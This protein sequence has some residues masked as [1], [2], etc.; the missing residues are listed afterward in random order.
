MKICSPNYWYCWFV[1]LQLYKHAKPFSATR[2]L[3]RRHAMVERCRTAETIALLSGTLAAARHSDLL[4][5]LRQLVRTSE[6]RVYTIV[7]GKMNEAKLANIAAVDAYALIACRESTLEACETRSFGA[8]IVTPLE[9]QMAFDSGSTWD[10]DYTTDFDH[11]LERKTL[12]E[13]RRASRV[14]GTANDVEDTVVHMSLNTG[15]IVERKRAP[16]P[17]DAPP[18]SS[19]ALA[20]S[21]GGGALVESFHSSAV[22]RHLQKS[23]FKGLDPRVGQDEPSPLEEGRSG[24]AAGYANEPGDDK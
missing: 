20:A 4:I 21:A 7:V 22:V 6:T 17:T 19:T 13:A 2:F 12:L 14:G 5:Y 23:T 16:V 9:L 8:P 18:S 15:R 24:I 11:V 10:S 1:P 3:M